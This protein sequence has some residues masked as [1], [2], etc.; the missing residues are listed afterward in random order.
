MQIP[1][2]K[3]LILHVVEADRRSLYR[4]AARHARERAARR[5]R[6]NPDSIRPKIISL[7]SEHAVTMMSM[8]LLIILRALSTT[9]MVPSSRYATPWL[10]S[11]AFLQD[12]HLHDFARGA[13]RL[14]RIGELVDVET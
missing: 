12:E 11:L 7:P 6:A 1:N 2:S 3:F 13:H 8:V 14:E 9:T 4:A 5:L 10:Y